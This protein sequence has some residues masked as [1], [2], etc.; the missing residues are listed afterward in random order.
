MLV[1]NQ[2]TQN[3]PVAF[4]PH[5]TARCFKQTVGAVGTDDLLR[6]ASRAFDLVTI[7]AVEQL[8]RGVQGEIGPRGPRIEG[9]F[10]LILKLG[11]LL[12]I[13]ALGMGLVGGVSRS[14]LPGRVGDGGVG[15]RARNV[16]VGKRARHSGELLDE[17]PGL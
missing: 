8:L 13:W 2:A 17:A 12:G 11:H 6:Y 16:G 10:V 5:H 4:T 15:T 9:L 1:H 14:P 7:L 3:S